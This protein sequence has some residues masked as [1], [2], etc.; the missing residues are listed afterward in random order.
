[1]PNETEKNAKYEYI[2]GVSSYHIG[3]PFVNQQKKKCY[4]SVPDPDSLDGKSEFVISTDQ[5]YPSR[6]KD[7]SVI[8]DR[9][10]IA[11]PKGRTVALSQKI[12]IK[13]DEQGQPVIVGKRKNG[14]DIPEYVTAVENK[15]P[16]DINAMFQAD[17]ERYKNSPEGKAKAAAKE[18]LAQGEA[19]KRAA[20]KV[21]GPDQPFEL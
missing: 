20:P 9:F 6:R 16:Q 4:I 2:Y 1:M 3:K 15:A 21:E 13:K 19:P 8:P 10:D 12:D 18:A 17:A 11:I 14:E 7:G 5:L